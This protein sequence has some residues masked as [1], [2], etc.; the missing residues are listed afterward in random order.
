M[1]DTN[2]TFAGYGALALGA[3]ICA[4]PHL[5]LLGLAAAGCAIYAGACLIDGFTELSVRRKQK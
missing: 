4:L 3:G 5:G 1:T 2:K